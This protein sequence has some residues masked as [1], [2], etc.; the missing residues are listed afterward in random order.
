MIRSVDYKMS[1]KFIVFLCLIFKVSTLDIT[2]PDHVET[3]P[4]FNPKLYVGDWYSTFSAY[5][6]YTDETSHCVRATYKE[7]SMFTF[8]PMNCNERGA[9]PSRVGITPSG[10]EATLSGGNLWDS[11]ISKTVGYDNKEGKQIYD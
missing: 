6:S 10:E 5:N 1:L 2:C 11:R 3:M 9:T 8:L 7:L 4:D